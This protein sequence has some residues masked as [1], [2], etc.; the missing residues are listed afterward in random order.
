MGK[1]RKTTEEG[2]PEL[3]KKRQTSRVA[4]ESEKRLIVVLE[5][6]HLETCKAGKEF[7]LLNIDEHRGILTRSG[8]DFSTAR[9]DITHQSLLMLFDSP[10]NRAGL[11]QVFIRTSNNVLIE[12]NPATRIP[13]TFKRFA[14][15]MVQLLHK[16]SITAAESSVKLLKVIKNPVTDHLPPGC[17]K[18]LMS[19]SADKVVPPSKLVP[20]GDEPIC[21]VVGAIAKGA[22]VTDYTEENISISNYPLSAALT[23][24]KLCTAFEEAWGVF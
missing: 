13:R 6:A 20:E 16:Y 14:G 7:S 11:L 5:G 22:I 23:C 24:T 2:E 12:I 19:Y 8:R 17:K 15:L 10:L 3:P 18:I 21:I 9:P 1:K 4:K